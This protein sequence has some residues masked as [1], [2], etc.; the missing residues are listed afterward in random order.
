MMQD[1]KSADV[2][3]RNPTHYAV[4]IKYDP[5][6]HSAPVITAKGADRAALRIIKIAEE[7]NVI[8]VENRPLA[9]ALY[10]RTEVDMEIPYE[11][12]RE[13]S[14]VLAFVYDL[15]KREPPIPKKKTQY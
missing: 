14:E 15:Q 11:F 2:V 13:V 12:Y 6:N 5:E 9:R 10:E 4:A 8:L 3:V 7:N 1:V